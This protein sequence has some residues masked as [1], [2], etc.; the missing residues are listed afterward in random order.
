MEK[1]IFIDEFKLKK[2]KMF[3]S[4]LLASFWVLFLWGFFES[5]IFALGL[6]MFIFLS[7][8]LGLFLWTLYKSKKSLKESISWITPIALIVLSF[9]IYEN[10][11]LKTVSIFIIFPFSF[12]FFYNLSFLE[13]GKKKYW[14]GVFLSLLLN[15]VFS[16]LVKLKEASSLYFGYIF[17]AE[18]GKN[19]IIKKV[20]FGLMLFLLV[21]LGVVVPLLSSADAVFSEKMIFIYEWLKSAISP[22]LVYKFLFLA[23]LSLLILSALFSWSREFSIKETEKKEEKKLDSIVS[24]IV[25]G[26]ISLI[27][28]LFLWVQAGRLFVGT[29][30][31]EFKEVESLVKSGFWQLFFLTILN[32]LIYIFAYKKTNKFV[33]GLLFAFTITSVLLLFS[34]GQRMMLYVYQY[35]FSY[36][37]LFA[38]Y[39]VLFCAILF[40]WLIFGFFSENKKNIMKF[41]IILFLWMYAMLTI[42]PVEQFI[43][44][45]NVYLK[46]NV[47]NSKIKLS[48]MRMLSSDVLFLAKKYRE[49]G[50]L[51]EKNIP[52][53]WVYHV[54]IPD[55]TDQDQF[56]DDWIKRRETDIVKKAWYEKNI[57]NILNSLK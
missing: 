39:T 35:G 17:P 37:K 12:A 10:P 15:R 54:G 16:F 32:I 28:L 53:P 43:F 51:G 5:G 21:A 34:A 3:F 49:D 4:F 38:L 24:G 7:G 19:L 29:L 1:D 18:K 2:Q 27:Y 56:W 31:F 20:I 14:N 57:S 26:G 36:E 25:I 52:T 46:N 8:F 50:T 6:N 48:E 42:F 33:Q 11:F 23:A 22:I 9:L 30:P 45:T 40:F 47:E 41:S 44:R 13:D 55:I